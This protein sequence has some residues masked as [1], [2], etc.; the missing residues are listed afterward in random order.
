M[1]FT[2]KEVIEMMKDGMGAGKAKTYLMVLI[3]ISFQLDRV[4]N[5]QVVMSKYNDK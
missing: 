5:Q 2:K 3:S 4:D 1:K